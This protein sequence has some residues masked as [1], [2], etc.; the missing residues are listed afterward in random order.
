MQSPLH[1]KVRSFKCILFFHPLLALSSTYDSK[2]ADAWC[3]AKGWNRIARQWCSLVLIPYT[4]LLPASLP[5]PS[6]PSFLT[7]MRRVQHEWE[8]K[9]NKYKKSLICSLSPFFPSPHPTYAAHLCFFVALVLIIFLHP[10]GFF[11]VVVLLPSRTQAEQSCSS[12]IVWLGKRSLPDPFCHLWVKLFFIIIAVYWWIQVFSVL[13]DK[14][15]AIWFNFGEVDT[16][17]SF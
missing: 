4:F 2:T 15:E 6:L 3:D 1:K 5:P 10:D 7:W 8:I 12:G 16:A 11:V 9:K 17:C 13:L 14:T